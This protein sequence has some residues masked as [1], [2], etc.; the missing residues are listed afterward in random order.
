MSQPT[1]S[2]GINWSFSSASKTQA[3]HRLREH[4]K[5]NMQVPLIRLQ[6]GV[7]SY[8]W[9]KK[10]EESAAARFGAATPSDFQVKSDQPYAEVCLEIS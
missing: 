3:E 7:N 4:L 10:G 8:D 1:G 6:C 2:S 9:G 5:D